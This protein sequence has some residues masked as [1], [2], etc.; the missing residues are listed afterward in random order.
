MLL[1]W[2]VVEKRIR[3]LIE[4]DKYLSPEGKEAY[5]QYRVEQD[6]RFS[7]ENKEWA[8][9]IEPYAMVKNEDNQAFCTGSGACREVRASVSIECPA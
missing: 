6:G 4:E 2:K 7:P 3:K 5:A 8:K 1:S 9:A